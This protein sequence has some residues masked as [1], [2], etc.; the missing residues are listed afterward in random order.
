FALKF[1]CCVNDLGLNPSLGVGHTK[2]D[3]TANAS[4][5]T[6]IVPG[7]ASNKLKFPERTFFTLPV[8][9]DKQL[10]W[11]T[12]CKREDLLDSMELSLAVCSNHFIEEHFTDS[13]GRKLKEDAIPMVFP[14]VQSSYNKNCILDTEDICEEE[15][16]VFID[17]CETII[18]IESDIDDNL[19]GFMDDGDGN[20]VLKH[21]GQLCRL[22]ASSTKDVIY[23][24]SSAGKQLNIADKINSSLPVL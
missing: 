6:C 23:I 18:K 3:V 14:V 24:F 7:C 8:S 15:E 2:S 4:P 22:C 10:Q 21:P 12:V 20:A 13:S 17:N 19:D 5:L 16:P 9:K 1:V 11:L